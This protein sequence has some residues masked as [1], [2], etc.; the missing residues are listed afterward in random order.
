[1]FKTKIET[2]QFF[3]I[4]KNKVKRT[5]LNKEIKNTQNLEKSYF[6]KEVFG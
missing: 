1:M 6:L 5:G 4:K 3:L 2:F